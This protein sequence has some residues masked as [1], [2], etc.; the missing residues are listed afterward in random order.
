MVRQWSKDAELSLLQASIRHL[1]PKYIADGLLRLYPSEVRTVHAVR[2]KL[3]ALRKQHDLMSD[4]YQDIPKTRTVLKTLLQEHETVE[5]TIAIPEPPYQGRYI[6]AVTSILQLTLLIH[7]SP[8]T[9]PLREQYDGEIW[10]MF[11]FLVFV[12]S[13]GPKCAGS[14]KPRA[15]YF[16][17]WSRRPRPL[18]TRF[19]CFHNGLWMAILPWIGSGHW[20]QRDFRYTI[21]AGR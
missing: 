13:S 1:S 3:K 12:L 6:F 20:F 4:G 5:S 9:S 21:L 17:S 2:S 19:C 11:Y 15:S 7:G 14:P 8:A 10:W 16:V 18:R